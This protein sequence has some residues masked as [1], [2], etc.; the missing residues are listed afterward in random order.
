[1]MKFKDDRGK[2]LGI[3]PD[4][5]VVPPDLQWTAME[6]LNSTYYPDMIAAGTGSQKLAANQLKG[7]LEIVVSPY[8]TDTN[9]WFL[10]ATKWIVKPIIFQSRVP[11]EFAALE[12]TSE[13]GFMRD[14]YVYGVR[15]RYNAGFGLW[16]T[17]FGSQV[18]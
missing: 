10:L 7:R 3:V 12:G 2:P 1:M 8:L 9:D 4:V 6:L 13:A 16:Q 5:L 17:A 14:Q 11:V 18:A 15:A